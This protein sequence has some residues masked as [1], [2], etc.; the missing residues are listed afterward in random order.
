MHVSM[1]GW[2]FLPSGPQTFP[3]EAV[4][5]ITAFNV[6]KKTASM[7]TGLWARI[8]AGDL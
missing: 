4:S 8:T 3:S 6:T 1:R 2:S 7:D 5:Q